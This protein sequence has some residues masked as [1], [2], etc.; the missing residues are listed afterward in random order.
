MEESWDKVICPHCKKEFNVKSNGCSLH[1]YDYI[2][3]DGRAFYMDHQTHTTEC[4]E[5]G[6]EFNFKENLIYGK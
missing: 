2:T 5:C 6:K 3:N 4:I 1:C